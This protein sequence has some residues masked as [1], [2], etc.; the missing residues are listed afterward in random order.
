MDELSTILEQ[1]TAIRTAVLP[2]VRDLISNVVPDVDGV[3]PYGTS[4]IEWLRPMIDLSDFNVYPT[5]GITEGLNWWFYKEQRGV[6]M[7]SGDYQWIKPKPGNG[8]ILYLSCPSS[9]DGNFCNIPTDIPVALDLAYVGS[10]KIRPIPIAD[11]VEIVFYSLSKSFGIRNIRTGWI[12]TRKQDKDLDLLTNSAKYYNYYALD[13]AE[14]ILNTFSVDYVYK[15]LCDEQTRICN[16]LNIT[17]SDSVWLA[18]SESDT[19]VKFKRNNSTA[20]IC[21][22]KVYNY[23]PQKT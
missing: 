2:E 12:F 11:N 9:I 5:N 3:R 23:E 22:S 18:N 21:L 7:L 6:D 10:T 20:R 16:L 1:S 8:K 14:K 17:P 19:Y 13:V 4:I 15:R